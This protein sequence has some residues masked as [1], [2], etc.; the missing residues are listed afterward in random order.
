MQDSEALVRFSRPTRIEDIARGL[1]VPGHKV[2]AK[3]FSFFRIFGFMAESNQ[4][5]LLSSSLVLILAL[6]T[7]NHRSTPTVYR[8][9]KKA[10]EAGGCAKGDGEIGEIGNQSFLFY[11]EEAFARGVELYEDFGT[12]LTVSAKKIH[13]KKHYVKA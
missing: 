13:L 3:S 1:Q 7:R 10:P 9:K 2:Q 4:T 11:R 5:K 12:K 8:A 6:L